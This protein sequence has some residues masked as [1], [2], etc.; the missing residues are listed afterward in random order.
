MNCAACIL[1][2]RLDSIVVDGLALDGELNVLDLFVEFDKC[3]IDSRDA[4][5][6][7]YLLSER[8]YRWLVGFQHID[9]QAPNLGHGV[10][11]PSDCK[12]VLIPS[13]IETLVRRY[14]G[15]MPRK[16]V[17]CSQVALDRTGDICCY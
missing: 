3:H 5:S 1:N 2:N 7:P 8:Q 12:G 15:A 13:Q 17:G 6:T 4:L 11:I 10:S 16:P 9:N 14:V